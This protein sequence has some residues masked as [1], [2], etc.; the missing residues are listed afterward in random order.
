MELLHLQDKSLSRTTSD[1]TE[2]IFPEEQP[3]DG[4]LDDE[5][6]TSL[7]NSRLPAEA[8]GFSDA[9]TVW[10]ASFTFMML[11]VAAV[12][13]GV[14]LTRPLAVVDVAVITQP[15]QDS[16]AENSTQALTTAPGILTMYVFASCFTTLN[17]S[18]A[19]HAR[20]FNNHTGCIDN[21]DLQWKTRHRRFSNSFADA[22]THGMLLTV[23]FIFVL[24]ALIVTVW[25]LIKL[26]R[27]VPGAGSYYFCSIFLLYLGQMLFLWMMVT[28]WQTW[29]PPQAPAP[30]G[31]VIFQ[32]AHRSQ[33]VI[34]T[35][36]VGL[37]VTLIYG[38]IQFCVV[39]AL[40]LM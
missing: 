3:G 40:C 8:M 32:T 14:A 35:G 9:G 12:C 17:E 34:T 37:L 15:L 4:P 18:V 10:L 25:T 39:V 5:N 7:T 33:G 21:Q 27:A 29:E 26:A 28:S 24:I 11:L 30:V 16:E 31:N 6:A 1:K 23:A 20:V 2:S 36:F 22:S 38:G 19:I 13:L